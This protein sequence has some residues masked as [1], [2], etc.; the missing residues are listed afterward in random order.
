VCNYV[1]AFALALGR[2]FLPKQPSAQSKDNSMHI[3]LQATIIQWTATTATVVVLP[4]DV[5]KHDIHRFR[6]ANLSC[7]NQRAELSAV[8]AVVDKGQRS[9]TCRN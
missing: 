5:H 3:I 9:T 8:G 1:Q 6:A 4:Y 2:Y 7:G